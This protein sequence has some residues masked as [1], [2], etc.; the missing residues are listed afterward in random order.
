MGIRCAV[1]KKMSCHALRAALFHTGGFAQTFL[2][3]RCY[4]QV[5]PAFFAP[6]FP[7]CHVSRN[8]PA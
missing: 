6:L 8:T 3:P 4:G 7:V 2:P 5:H 1:F